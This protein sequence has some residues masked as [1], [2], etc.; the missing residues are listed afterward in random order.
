MTIIDEDSVNK[1]KNTLNGWRALFA[2]APMEITLTGMYR[3]GGEGEEGE[4]EQNFF[5]QVEILTQLDALI[6]LVLDV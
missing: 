1:L 4:Y 3:E 6:S 5:E 2:S